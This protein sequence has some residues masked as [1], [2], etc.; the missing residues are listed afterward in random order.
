MPPRGVSIDVYVIVPT[1]LVHLIG[2]KALKRSE[3]AFSSH[4]ELGEGSEVEQSYTLASGDVFCG[5]RRR[6]FSRLP[7]C[8]A[9]RR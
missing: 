7:A 5:N 2:R 3:R 4:L 6:P 9:T 1:G 8:P